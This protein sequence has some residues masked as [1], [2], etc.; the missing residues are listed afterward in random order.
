MVANIQIHSGKR[1]TAG[2]N[3]ADPKYPVQFD[4]RRAQGIP[5][6]RRPALNMLRMWRDWPHVSSLSQETDKRENNV[7]RSNI[8]ICEHCSTQRPIKGGPQKDTAE[9]A[10]PTEQ[11]S[12]TAPMII[13]IEHPGQG[14]GQCP[15]KWHLNQPANKGNSGHQWKKAAERQ[16]QSGTVEQQDQRRPR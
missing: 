16:T 4:H 5:T 3:D 12:H 7:Q 15:S 6:A 10:S 1:H 14:N 9:R 13:D 11:V 2:Y 8:N